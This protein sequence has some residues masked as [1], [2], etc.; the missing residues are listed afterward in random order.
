MKKNTIFC[1]Y[2]NE[3]IANT[4][5]FQISIAHQDNWVSCFLFA[6]SIKSMK[7][8][9]VIWTDDLI[10]ILKGK[11]KYTTAIQIFI[12]NIQT[13]QCSLYGQSGRAMPPRDFSSVY[14]YVS[15]TII[16]IFLWIELYILMDG[17]SQYF[18]NRDQWWK[19][20]KIQ[21]LPTRTE[22]E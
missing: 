18:T 4:F 17:N 6:Q 22:A 5:R 14:N 9:K 3:K 16:E 11:E 10:W 8:K 13:V 15:C 7:G 1:F 2:M 19:K 12:I 21:L 20:T